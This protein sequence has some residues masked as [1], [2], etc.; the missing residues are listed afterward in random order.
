MSETTLNVRIQNRTDLEANWLSH[1][2]VLL[3]GEIAVSSDKGNL[4]KVGDGTSKWSELTYNSAVSADAANYANYSTQTLSDNR[5]QQIDTTYVSGIN[6]EQLEDSSVKITVTKGDSSSKVFSF[7]DKDTTYEVMTGATNT[8]E[9]A[10]GLVPKTVAGD[11]RK[12]LRGD[13]TWQS[14]EIGSIGQMTGAT[15]ESDGETGLVPAPGTGQQNMFLRGDGSWAT[16][17]DTTYSNMTGC[18]NLAAG[19]AG[20]VP[21]PEASSVTKFLSNKGS[22]E[23]VDLSVMTGASSITDG[24]SGLVPAP[25]AGNEGQ[26]LRGD[27]TWAT[28]INTTYE[29]ASPD[30]LGL[31]KLYTSTGSNTDGSMTQDA[32]TVA[33]NSKSTTTHTHN[34]GDIVSLDASK[35]TGIISLDRLPAGALER[36]VVVE[37]D[38]ARF[39]LTIDEVQNG[40]TVKVNESGVM[41]FVKDQTNLNNE[42]GYAVYTAGAATSVPWS[43]ITDVPAKF[44]PDSHYHEISDI[45]DLELQLAG[46]APTSHSHDFSELTGTVAVSQLPTSGVT[47]GTYKSITVDQYG[48]VTAGSN[49]TTLAGYGIT[50]AASKTHTH[51]LEVDDIT[52]LQDELDGKSD[53]GHTHSYLPLAGGTLTGAVT[54]KSATSESNAYGSTNPK[55]NFSNI[56]GNQLVSLIFTDYDSIANPASLTL[57]GNAGGEYFIAPNIKATTDIYEAGTKLSEKYQAKGNYAGSSSDGGAATSAVKW[58]T[59]RNINGMSINGEA[60]RV[61]YGTCSTAAAT[62]AKVVDCTGFAL[63]TGAEIT[64]KFTVTNTAASPTLNVNGTGAK[65]IYY[66]GAAIS[67][68]YLAA[69]R[70]YTFRYN[71]TQYELVG[72]INTDTNT[73]AT[74]TNTTTAADYRVILSTNANDTTETNTLRKSTNFK[75][76]PSTGAFYAKG[77]TKNDLSGQTLDINTLNLSAGTPHKMEYVEKTNGGAANITNIPVT[78][79]PFILTVESV[80]WASTTDYITKQTFQSSGDKEKVYQRWCTSGTWSAWTASFT[81]GIMDFGFEG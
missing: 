41:Y 8:S 44:T 11:N 45:T 40:D 66:R 71:G 26:F 37:N 18:T 31:A 43:G 48:R 50:D 63:I 52:G 6:V 72:D 7:A 35:L 80:R 56:D 23:E 25:K 14:V 12:F 28:P 33:L 9:G 29:A 61:N 47:A 75:A 17:T 38:T 79:Q 2:P 22:W 10:S 49:P 5:G 74:Q 53:T 4:Y 59:A 76:N 57:I 68:G 58:S 67:A 15:A 69:N 34:S 1:D 36:F 54:I 13:G 21:A 62:A 77:Y 64:V 16:P 20:L 27:G 70:T 42:S 60:N 3:K 55:L 81:M 19:T 65:A 39:A 46:K 51:V 73:K 32:I 24:S 30:T 78:G